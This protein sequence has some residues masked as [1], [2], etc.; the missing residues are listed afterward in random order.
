MAMS[1]CKAISRR[2][3]QVLVQHR[4]IRKIREAFSGREKNSISPK[5]KKP[6]RTKKTLEIKKYVVTITCTLKSNGRGK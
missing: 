2:V 6:Q 3:L 5:K 1:S 4:N